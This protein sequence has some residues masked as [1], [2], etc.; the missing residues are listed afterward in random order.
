M[1]S[2]CKPSPLLY[3][4][5]FVVFL[6]FMKLATRVQYL[7]NTAATVCHNFMKTNN[8]KGGLSL[9]QALDVFHTDYSPVPAYLCYLVED[10]AFVR[11]ALISD[12]VSY[13]LN[14]EIHNIV[15]SFILD[16][17]FLSLSQNDTKKS[18]LNLVYSFCLIFCPWHQFCFILYKFF[19]QHYH[20]KLAL[21]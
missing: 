19:N 15:F 4:Y 9:V 21:F 12:S 13:C 1:F 11:I 20:C 10:V 3:E 14:N 5:T 7:H 16:I 8:N 6:F 2:L 18:A 17:H